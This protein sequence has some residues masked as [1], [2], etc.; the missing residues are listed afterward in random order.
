[1]TQEQKNMLRST[2]QARHSNKS[3]AELLLVA[4]SL[5]QQI[6]T[7]PDDMVEPLSVEAEVVMELITAIRKKAQTQQ[8]AYDIWHK[9]WPEQYQKEALSNLLTA[10]SPNG[11]LVA[12][13]LEETDGL[14]ADEI[15]SWYDE[16]EC[17]DDKD[18]QRLLDNL[19]KEEVLVKENDRYYLNQLCMP[20]LLPVLGVGKKWRLSNFTPL[21][22]LVLYAMRQFPFVCDI[23]INGGFLK[24]ASRSD[25]IDTFAVHAETTL[26]PAIWILTPEATEQMKLATQLD[27]IP[28]M[29]LEEAKV[30]IPKVMRALLS[31]NCLDKKAGFYSLPILGDRRFQL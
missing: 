12:S 6:A 30:E 25:A 31:K 26:Y 5:A 1:M 3:E 19:V 15:R 29:T 9:K 17:L 11:Q 2:Y 13:I 28:E 8:N 27:V 20:D 23:M 10:V 24:N 18:Y 16:L 21:E 14:T 22:R 4:K 7:V